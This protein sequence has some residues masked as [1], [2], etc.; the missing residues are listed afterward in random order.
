[1]I[2][3]LADQLNAKLA[4]VARDPGVEFILTTPL[5]Q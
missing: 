1:M 2:R 3:A 4:I 5:A